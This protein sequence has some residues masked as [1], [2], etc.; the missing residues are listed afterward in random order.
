[1]LPMKCLLL[2]YGLALCSG[3]ASLGLESPQPP[4]PPPTP[5]SGSPLPPPTPSSGSP[6]PPPAPSSP[7]PAQ[8][9]ACPEDKF[10]AYLAMCDLSVLE[11][12]EKERHRAA[13]CNMLA[14]VEAFNAAGT[15]TSRRRVSCATADAVRRP[16]GKGTHGFSTGLVQKA[17]GPPTL[18]Q[19]LVRSS[20]PFGAPTVAELERDHPDVD[21]SK[22]GPLDDPW[23]GDDG[24]PIDIVGPVLDQGSCGAC[25]AFAGVQQLQSSVAFQKKQSLEVE[26][27]YQQATSCARTPG[28]PEDGCQGGFPTAVFGYA[29]NVSQYRGG[30][31]AAGLDYPY[32]SGAL[33]SGG[34]NA[35]TA[36]RV[37]EG[38][39]AAF[40]VSGI[41]AAVGMPPDF[42]ASAPYKPLA[43]YESHFWSQASHPFEQYEAMIKALHTEGPLCVAVCVS[44]A[45]NWE[46]YE[47]GIHTNDFSP[48]SRCKFRS[49]LDHAVLLVGY[50]V[51]AMNLTN[52]ATNEI[53]T[54]GIKYWKLK[55]SWGTGWGEAGYIRLY[56]YGIPPPNVTL[57]A[58]HL[59]LD[60][61]DG[62]RP[63]GTSNMMYVYF[64][65]WGAGENTSPPPAPPEQPAPPFPPPAPPADPPLT[66]T[67]SSLGFGACQG[68]ASDPV[69]TDLQQDSA[70]SWDDR[71]EQCKDR[72][73]QDVG[74]VP[75]PCK[76]F[77]ISRSIVTQVAFCRI[78]YGD[79]DRGLYASGLDA[80]FEVYGISGPPA[81]PWSPSPPLPP[82]PPPLSPGTRM[83][84]EGC[85]CHK[86]WTHSMS[87]VTVSDYC[88]TP[89][90]DPNGEWCFVVDQACQN[91]NW[92]YCA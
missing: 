32:K 79:V 46:G 53:E 12:E 84:K 73:G 21:W 50:G 62:G 11:P 58:N 2:A 67:A 87:G 91:R 30:G 83:T 70:R 68:F 61:C 55:N 75:G 26:L 6:L 18:G 54:V 36:C 63:C 37:P 39:E 66:L 69:I 71:F 49:Q 41:A 44:G 81:P 86:E 57:S 33:G 23:L 42:D 76:C 59:W 56:R 4:L 80:R 82:P 29:L 24:E 1:V 43:G 15:S 22:G 5:S 48:N 72:C 25:W 17:E 88:G 45:N 92:G 19:R 16:E 38:P 20:N 47:S 10:Q 8:P 3:F 34:S 52:P 64:D 51:E 13:Y 90:N 35:A 28:A 89:D 60:A 40:A 27:S 85:V 77:T 31:I 74:D 78:Y 14:E 9:S 65:I 7:L